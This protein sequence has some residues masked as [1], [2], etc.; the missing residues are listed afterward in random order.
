[1]TQR[2]IAER[3][4]RS[5][6]TK[7]E[8]FR[9]VTML[10]DSGMPYFFTLW[11]ECRPTPFEP[12]K[13]PQ[14]IDLDFIKLQIQIGY[15]V[16]EKTGLCEASIIFDEAAGDGTLEILDMTGRKGFVPEDGSRYTGLKAES[17]FKILKNIFD[18]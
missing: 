2:E 6:P 1:M 18:K 14:E 10:E 11:E 12:A 9:L 17:A 8:I 15:A 7:A 4:A 13:D 16:S 3:L 5:S